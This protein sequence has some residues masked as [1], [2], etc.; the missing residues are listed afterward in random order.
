MT[1]L[2]ICKLF[3]VVLLLSYSSSY[4]ISMFKEIDRTYKTKVKLYLKKAN[5]SP[6]SLMKYAKKEID[7]IDSLDFG[8]TSF[9]EIKLNDLKVYYTRKLV[10]LLL[11]KAK[12][13]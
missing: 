12:S 4:S 2:K 3:I 6:D 7:F 5:N 11:N 8:G 10:L 9:D 1:F 13:N